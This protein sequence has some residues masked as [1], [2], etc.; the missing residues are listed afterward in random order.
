MSG[1]NFD[2]APR[3][4][5][6]GRRHIRLMVLSRREWMPLPCQHS[7][8]LGSSA[9]VRLLIC[10]ELLVLLLEVLVNDEPSRTLGEVF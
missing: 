10:R 5:G 3:K 9:V 6:C 1:M 2:S 7:G 8:S 4:R